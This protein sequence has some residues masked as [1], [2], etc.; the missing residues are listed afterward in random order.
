MPGPR[1][2]LDLLARASA[3]PTQD[4]GTPALARMAG[5]SDAHLHRDFVRVAGETPKAWTTR[6]RLASAAERL[7]TEDASIE[8]VALR[9]GF[10]SHATFTR[11]VRRAWDTTPTALRE[12]PSAPAHA[13]CLGLYHLSLKPRSNAMSLQIQLVERAPQP[14]LQMRREV[15][16][17]GLQQAM[18]ECL[19]AVFAHCQQHGIQM[20]GPPFTRYLDM[21]RGF[22]TIEAGMPVVGGEGA[23]EILAGELPG[24][25]VA[26]A[27]HEGPYDTLG[28][29]H[30]ALEAW[31]KAQGLEPSGGPWE[32]YLTDP[33]STPDPADWRTEVCLPVG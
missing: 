7:R 16:H 6:V 9:S 15:P 12:G 26:V 18:A 20:A 24:G 22:F 33:G 30:S 8:D 23:G 19:P 27:I 1:D 13:P 3:D 4:L 10:A 17:D 25:R 29:T 32:S 2:I 21:S 28:A 11:A 5:W 31:V 14:V